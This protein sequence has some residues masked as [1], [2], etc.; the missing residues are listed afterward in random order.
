MGAEIGATTSVFPYD[1]R[2]ADYLRATTRQ[3]TAE[4]AEKLKECLMPDEEV[5]E[6]P[7][8]Y[9][10]QMIEIDLS[11][12]EPYINGP[13]SPDRAW[14]LSEFAEAVRKYVIRKNFPLL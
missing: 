14:K 9:Y 2:M 12:L 3:E 6:A 7:E 13:Y 5:L 8:A 1:S 11:T 10:D 4:F